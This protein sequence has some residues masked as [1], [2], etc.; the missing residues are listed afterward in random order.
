MAELNKKEEKQVAAQ[1]TSWEQLEE[2]ALKY[3]LYP[4]FPAETLPLILRPVER[5]DQHFVYFP[6]GTKALDLLFGLEG[7]PLGI[8]HPKISAAIKEASDSFGYVT[9]VN[10]TR[11]SVTASKLLM[12]DILGPDKWA[13]ACRWVDSGSEAVELALQMARLYTNRPNIIT[14]EWAYHG[15]TLG[16]GSCSRLGTI[17]DNIISATE[18]FQIREL[19]GEPGGFHVVPGQ[20]CYRC[21]LGHRYPNCKMSDGR[22]PCVDIIGNMIK[23]IGVGSVAAIITEIASGGPGIMPAKEYV[24][25]LRQLTRDLGI[26]WIDDE[27][28]MGFG[29][30]GAWF[31]YQKYGQGATPDIMLIGKGA[32]NSALP[33]GGVVVSKEIASWFQQH[34]WPSG[35]TFFS[36]PLVMAA[37]AASLQTMIEEKL[38][39]KAVKV[40]RSFGNKLRKLQEKHKSV[41]LVSGDGLYWVVELVKNRETREPFIKEDRNANPGNMFGWPTFAV[42][43][44]I[45]E[46]GVLAGGLLP[47]TLTLVPNCNFTEELIDMA[48]DAIDYGLIAADQMCD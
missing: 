46:K 19:P 7:V 5:V 47:N 33:L 15:W 24:P 18:P 41:G 3:C 10:P 11:Y 12:E 38:V 28:L 1:E 6:D 16:A 13:G 20:N 2:W 42:H 14:R 25:Q 27:I 35:A 45:F 36:H 22:L 30:V 31:A 37:L 48:C 44:R 8:R 40:G 23:A 34:C 21:S 43:A 29:R 17:A 32:I 26:L 4:F 39:E 9:E